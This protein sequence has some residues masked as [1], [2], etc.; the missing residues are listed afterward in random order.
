MPGILTRE[1]IIKQ[2][3][4]AARLYAAKAGSCCAEASEKR[5]DDL[6]A[7]L[8]A[9]IARQI[10]EEE[11]EERATAP[12][13]HQVPKVNPWSLDYS[14]FERAVAELDDLPPAVQ[15]AEIAHRLA[16]VV[17]NVKK[18]QCRPGGASES[19]SSNTCAGLDS[20]D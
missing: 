5:A 13:T 7:D 16:G 4:E 11:R 8:A 14:R 18:L 2:V 17:E 19:R 3:T 6:C 10:E 12:P 20:L 1:G 15:S 9:T